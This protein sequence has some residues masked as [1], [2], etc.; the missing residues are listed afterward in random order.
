MAYS[1][2]PL[3]RMA[4]QPVRSSDERPAVM[5]GEFAAAKPKV[6][7]MSVPEPAAV[8][9]CR[10]LS[11][12]CESVSTMKRSVDQVNAAPVTFSLIFAA[13]PC[14]S[15]TAEKSRPVTSCSAPSTVILKAPSV[16]LCRAVKAVPSVKA[17]PSMRAG[18]ASA[19]AVEA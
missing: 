7:L 16:M 18:R 1:P 3:E 8:S 5:V 15:S 12:V 6:E 4:T 17:A 14:M 11:S 2:L 13:A 10:V 9:A 19:P